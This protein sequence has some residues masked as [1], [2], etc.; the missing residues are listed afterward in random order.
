MLQ[1]EN[2]QIISWLLEQ[3]PTIIVMGI[4]MY[5]LYKYIKTKDTIIE[6]KDIALMTLA[7]KII[8]VTSLM[9]VK[10]DINTKEHEEVIKT[11][12]EIKELLIKHINRNV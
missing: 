6:A 5:F 4:V 1:I 11:L 7:E 12:R 2:I 8:T 10:A 9:E 3:I